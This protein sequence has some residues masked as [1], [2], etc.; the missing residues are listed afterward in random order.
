MTVQVAAPLRVRP[1]RSTAAQRA[2][3][4]R[5]QRAAQDGVTPV[6]TRGRT[7]GAGRVATRIPFVATIIAL[8]GV[9][10]A[11]TLLLTTRAA[12]DSYQLSTARAY[13]ESLVQQRAVLQRDVEAGMSAPVL[14][15]RAA[16]LGMIPS[17]DVARLVVGVDGSVSV[18][19]EPVPAQGA[20][21]APLSSTTARDDLRVQTPLAGSAGSENPR[22]LSPEGEQPQP[23]ATVDPQQRAAAV[24]EAPR[25]A[26]VD[27]APQSQEAP[28]DREEAAV[29]VL[30]GSEEDGPR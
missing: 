30:P 8:L 25:A 12:E 21:V 19:G 29:E 26:V 27:G 11:L 4:R 28:A 20:P 7:T 1:E 18:V 23:Q 6:Q 5:N 24:A 16:E 15:Q 3:R 22:P 9:G 14:A 2:Y 17:G 10:M 13:N